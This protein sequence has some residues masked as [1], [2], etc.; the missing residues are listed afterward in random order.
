MKCMGW[1]EL[2]LKKIL[3]LSYHSVDFLNLVHFFVDK[4]EFM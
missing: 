4:V 3:A 1:I 2:R